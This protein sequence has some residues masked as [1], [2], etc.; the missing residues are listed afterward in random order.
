[1][2]TLDV[3]LNG[4]F[5]MLYSGFSICQHHDLE[6]R[7]QNGFEIRMTMEEVLRNTIKTLKENYKDEAVRYFAL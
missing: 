5:Y 2:S 4:E 7:K 6:L 1:M 3:N